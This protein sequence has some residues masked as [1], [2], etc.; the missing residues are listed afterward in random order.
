MVRGAREQ[1][2]SHFLEK[3]DELVDIPDDQLDVVDPANHDS[4]PLVLC[5]C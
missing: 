4:L 5:E 3:R 2:E 1:P